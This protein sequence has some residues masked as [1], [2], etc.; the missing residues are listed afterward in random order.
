VTSH[1]SYTQATTNPAN[2]ADNNVTAPTLNG[3]SA[4]ALELIS[5]PPSQYAPGPYDT[6]GRKGNIV[7]V[8]CGVDNTMAS[9]GAGL[10]TPTLRW[11]W[12]EA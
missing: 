9:A 6:T 2:T 1:G 5:L 12:T 11:K 7:E 4:T 3:A 10:A 8:S